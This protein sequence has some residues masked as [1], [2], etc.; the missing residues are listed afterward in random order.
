MKPVSGALSA[1]IH[2]ALFTFKKNNHSLLEII[3]FPTN[4]KESPNGG[5][6]FYILK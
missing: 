2:W 5:L 6:F 1:C 4:K 3:G